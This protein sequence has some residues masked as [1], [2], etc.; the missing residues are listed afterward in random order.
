M[1]EALKQIVER[2]KLT[3]ED[4]FLEVFAGD[5]RKTGKKPYSTFFN[6]SKSNIENIQS[7][8]E[9]YNIGVYGV[10]LNINPLSKA[11]R[12]KPN[13]KKI[14]Y[15]FVDLDDAEEEHNEL[16]KDFLNAKGI[17][18][19][20]NAKSGHGYHFLIPV[21]LSTDYEPKVKGFLNYLKEHCT[22]R[23][24]LATADL[25]RLMRFPES[26]HNKDNEAKQLKTLYTRFPETEEVIL[27]N[28]LILNFQLEQKK[29]VKDAQYQNEIL[30][31]DNFFTTIL[32]SYSNYPKY[33]KY[34][35]SAKDRNNNFIKNLG[36]FLKYNGNF[37][38]DAAN[39][40]NGWEPSRIQ[41]VDGWIKKANEN[42]FVVNYIELYKWSKDN[43]LEEWEHL[44]LQQIQESFLDRYEFYYLEDEKPENAYLM[45]YPEKNYYVQKKLSDILTNI[46]YDCVE[47]GIDLEEEFKPGDFIEDWDKKSYSSKIKTYKNL[48]DTKIH[49][50]KRIRLVYNINYEPS[51]DKFIY[52]NKKK[53]FNI[54]NKTDLWDYNNKESK[55]Q[56]ENIKELVMNL[57]GNEK[58]N[59][60]YFNKW[61]SWIIQNPKEKLPTAIIFQGRQGSGKG[62][63][64]NLILDRIFGGNC[65]EINQTQLESAFNEYL[66]GKQI[67][68]AN[69]VMHNENRQTLP[70]VLKNLVTD[71]YITIARKFKKEITTKNYTHW[72]FCTNNDNPIKIDEDDRRYSVFYSKKLPQGFG[73]QIRQNL[74]Y[75]LEEYISFLKSLDVIFDE[76]S[77]P[78]MTEAKKEVIELNKDSVERFREA[79]QQYE[80]LWHAYIDIFGSDQNYKLLNNF[81]DGR[82]YI[83]TDNFYL[84]YEKYCDKMKEFGKFNKLNFSKK[85][86]N[87]GIKS[88]VKREN[89]THRTYDVDLLDQWIKIE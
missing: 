77:E 4:S 40:L 16:V 89:G 71:E 57:C 44:L 19:S 35:D 83:P 52:L 88:I 12:T 56:F 80:S 28:E 85:L 22:Q 43:G 33:Y 5:D 25:G 29:G 73:K 38:N 58:K 50:E 72:I 14:L 20:Y 69:E 64:K 55:F 2:H 30:R 67:I 48:I 81:G 41:A 75:E 49:K 68:M 8:S 11:K 6:L 10:F 24:D 63:F 53:F 34:L 27:N 3:D 7:E 62:T 66:I 51:D 31:T 42:N 59:Y 32:S 79:L 87:K 9:I 18:Y 26:I 82:S 54:Y 45:Y 70:N 36:I 39:F 37:Y 21:D 65:Q 84:L 47:S 23:V 60:D 13:V 76:V 86:S 46:Y 1:N 17:S 61:L 15:I 78:I 74:E